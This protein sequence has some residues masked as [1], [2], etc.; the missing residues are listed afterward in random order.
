MKRQTAQW[1]RKA[2]EDWGGALALAAETPPL[3]DLACFH[4]QQAAEK[5]LKALLQENGAAV[6]KIHDLEDLLDLLLPYDA[7]LAPLRRG[8]TSLS[9]FAVDYRYPGRRAS[10]RQMTAGVRHAEGIRREVRTRLG[11]PV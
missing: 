5:Y 1:V 2:E 8:L 4:C 6:P 9:R 3:C 10:K 11:L 7:T